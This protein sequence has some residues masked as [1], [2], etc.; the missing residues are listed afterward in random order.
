MLHL[1]TTEHVYASPVVCMTV[2]VSA[3]P[4][5]RMLTGLP[6]GHVQGVSRPLR[7]ERLHLACELPGH[8]ARYGGQG[9]VGA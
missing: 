9:V 8:P 7:P 1:H 5:P 2:E 3:L 6:G 4:A